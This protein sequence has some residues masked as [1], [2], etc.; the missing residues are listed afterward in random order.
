V[1]KK[2]QQ[3]HEH[4]HIAHSAPVLGGGPPEVGPSGPSGHILDF[5]DIFIW[6]KNP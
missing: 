6:A 5:I 2:L 4:A 3:K 1:R